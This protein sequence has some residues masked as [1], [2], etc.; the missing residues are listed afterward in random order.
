MSSKKKTY[1]VYELIN[2]LTQD[3]FYIGKGTGD[4][5][6]THELEARRGGT[7]YGAQYRKVAL[8]REIWKGGGT[9]QKRIVF[10]TDDEQEAFRQERER[11]KRRM[12]SRRKN[13]EQKDMDMWIEGWRASG[14]RASLIMHQL[15]AAVVMYMFQTGRMTTEELEVLHKAYLSDESKLKSEQ[16]RKKDE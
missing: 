5:I 8:I 11:R 4:R 14:L 16:E 15:P 2:S 9:V 13:M 10:E 1:Y 3:V 6:H 7:Y 12:R